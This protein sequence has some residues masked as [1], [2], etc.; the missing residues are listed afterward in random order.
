[1]ADRDAVAWP[2]HRADAAWEIPGPL[3]IGLVKRRRAAPIAPLG[4]LPDFGR[5]AEHEGVAVAAIAPAEWLLLGAPPLVAARLAAVRAALADTL[6]LALDLSAGHATL[7]LAG[8]DARARLAAH[9]PLD[10]RGFTTGMVAR[11]LIGDCHA[12]ILATQGGY[13]LIVDRSR[14]ASVAALLAQDP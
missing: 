3:G 6:H 10:L 13:R 7:D 11:S 12:T 14:R 4:P 2:A 8:A 5:I 9:C 1:M